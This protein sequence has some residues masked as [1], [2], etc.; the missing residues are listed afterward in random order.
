LQEIEKRIALGGG[1]QS[2]FFPRCQLTR[3]EPQY[4][5]QVRL[6]VSVHVYLANSQP[7]LSATSRS[8]DKRKVG[9][10]AVENLEDLHATRVVQFERMALESAQKASH[11]RKFHESAL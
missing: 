6:T 11:R 3:R 10:K 7:S 4:A 5:K 2:G 8:I 9:Q 1:Y